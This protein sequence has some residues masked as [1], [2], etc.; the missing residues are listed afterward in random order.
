M[1]TTTTISVSDFYARTT[2]LLASAHA[3]PVKLTRHGAPVAVIVSPDFYERA[4]EA[5]GEESEG[6]GS[7]WESVGEGDSEATLD[8]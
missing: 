4:S 3:S 8:E 2:E 1:A 7:G 5:L 6:E